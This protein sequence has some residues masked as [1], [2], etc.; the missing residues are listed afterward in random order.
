[1]ITD[2]DDAYANGAHIEGAEAYPDRWAGEAAA[3]RNGLGDRGELDLPYGH[4]ERRVLDFFTP[5]AEPKGVV[6]FVHG[7]YW[8]A[9]DKSYWSH[10][11]AGPLA[12]GWAVAM[13]SYTLAPHARISLIK[14]EIAGAVS[15]AG[16]KVDGPI[17]LTGHSAGGHLATRM[18]CQDTPIAPETHERIE[19][20][21]SISGV[22]DLR[23]LLK[24]EMNKILGLDPAEARAESPALKTPLDSMRV[25]AWVGADERPEFVRQSALLANIWRGLGAETRAV[26]EDGKHHFDVIEGLAQPDSKLTEAL[27]S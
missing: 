25:T 27:L 13:P 17:R 20:V 14:R 23:P 26:R 22:H 24:T 8:K 21:L 11:A 16:A 18:V 7:G 19:H 6:I 3:F 10:L 2:W 4:G 5:E 12:R 15:V 1:M 9:F